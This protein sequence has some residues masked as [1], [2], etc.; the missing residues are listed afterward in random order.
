MHRVW[1]LSMIAVLSACATRPPANPPPQV[2]AWLAAGGP[3]PP[4]VAECPFVADVDLAAMAEEEKRRAGEALVMRGE[5][6][7]RDLFDQVRI[8][9]DARTPSAEAPVILT[10][11]APPGGMHSNT[12]WSV[13]WKEPDG[14]WWFWRQNRTNEPPPPPPY[15][16]APDATEA[17]KA[18]YQAAMAQYP[19]AD[20]V[21]WPPTYGPLNQVQAAA[22]EKSLADPCRAWEPDRWP[23]DPPLRRARAQPGPPP[24][25][26]WTP[27]HVWIQEMGRPPR[28]ISAPNERESHARTL[29]SAAAY[30]RP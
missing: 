5:A 9:G 7:L 22:V 10:A 8:N 27:T 19:P 28:L 23:W 21:R 11:V 26:D 18:A 24:P 17:E 12:I 29:H 16:P 15:P 6:Y 4:P 25:Q 30:P 3:Q 1:A 13:V 20:H 2:Q 14:A